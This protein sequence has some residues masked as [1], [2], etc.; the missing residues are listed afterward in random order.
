V[1]ND[2]KYSEIKVQGAYGGVDA[3]GINNQGDIVGAYAT[4]VESGSCIGCHST[5]PVYLHKKHHIY[6]DHGFLLSQGKLTTV[7]V[8]FPD[9]KGTNKVAGIS[10]DGWMVGIYTDKTGHERGF[11]VRKP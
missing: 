8:K 3:Y 11:K 6:K 9:A 7:D 2:G 4:I 5:P 10:D 1:L